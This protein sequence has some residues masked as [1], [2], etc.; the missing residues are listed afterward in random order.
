MKP[1]N[2]GFAA[3]GS[4][5][6]FDFGL[7]TCVKKRQYCTQ[8]YKMTKC[9]G[10]L[11]YMAPEVALGKP[12]SEKVD[13]FSYSM[14]LWQMAKGIQP[15]CEIHQKNEFLNT[16]IKND[17]R[18]QVDKQWPKEF[19]NLLTRCWDTNPEKRPCFKNIVEYL[20]ILLNQ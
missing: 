6:L 2:V 7:S 9:T 1:D 10:S 4:I 15:F 18:P 17:E 13:V 12:Y 3:D 20:E 11:R 16:I 19:S 8:Q 14:V 5:R